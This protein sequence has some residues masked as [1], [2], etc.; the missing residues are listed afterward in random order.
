MEQALFSMSFTPVPN[1]EFFFPTF[2]V[3]YSPAMSVPCY[4]AMVHDSPKI[5]AAAFSC[6]CEL[7]AAFLKIYEL[8]LEGLVFKHGAAAA[9]IG[10]ILMTLI[11]VVSQ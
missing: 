7:V 4:S 5:F 9:K 6:C 8:R 11:Y 2:A 3:V 1:C 10:G